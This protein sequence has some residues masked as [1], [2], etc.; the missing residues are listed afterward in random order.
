MYSIFAHSTLV[1]LQGP[2]NIY[3]WDRF[4][5][6]EHV[7]LFWGEWSDCCIHHRDCD[8]HGAKNLETEI[9]Q[10]GDH[11]IGLRWLV[12]LPQLKTLELVF[13][14]GW[15]NFFKQTYV[16]LYG[17]EDTGLRYWH[18]ESLWHDTVSSFCKSCKN[19]LLMD[20]PRTLEKV[21]F[22]GRPD[23]HNATTASTQAINKTWEIWDVTKN[24]REWR[25]WEMGRMSVDGLASEK[26]LGELKEK[27][28]VVDENQVCFLLPYPPLVCPRGTPSSRALLP[29]TL[30][31]RAP[32][33]MGTDKSIH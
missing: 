19:C 28:G 24:C 1:E 23:D 2:W 8:R 7:S 4:L 5:R 18:S 20:L 11:L 21:I 10:R 31:F 12:K 3:I 15:Y 13:P 33:W 14:D 17:D 25:I 22:L 26:V 27:I 6:I 30:F 32:S 29:R 9:I 16:E